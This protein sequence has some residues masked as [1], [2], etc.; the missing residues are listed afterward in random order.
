MTPTLQSSSSTFR[1][2]VSWTDHFLN[3]LFPW[4]LQNGDHEFYH[5]FHFISQ[6][7]SVKETL[8]HQLGLFVFGKI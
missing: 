4:G 6:N 5:P 8:P 2:K 3:K 1:S 7:S